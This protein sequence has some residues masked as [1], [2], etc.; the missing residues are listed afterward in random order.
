MGES[1]IKGK[2][3]KKHIYTNS[4]FKNSEMRGKAELREI[5]K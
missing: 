4:I 3:C 1:G 2:Q 5:K